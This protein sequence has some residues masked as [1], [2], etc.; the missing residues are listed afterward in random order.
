[1]PIAPGASLWHKF[2][3]AG[4]RSQI[5]VWLTDEA[6]IGLN[7]SVWTPEQVRL[8]QSG[9]AVEPVGRGS[10]DPY[11]SGDLSWSGN[12]PQAGSYYVRVDN[13]TSTSGQYSLHIQGSGVW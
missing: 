1:V 7:F 5:L 4:D 13:G 8:W 9:A 12:F 3:Y 6:G 11:A 10:F 2:E